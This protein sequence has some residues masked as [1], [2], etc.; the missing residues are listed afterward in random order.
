MK[1]VIFDCDG[2]LVDSQHMI[3]EAMRAAFS[4]SGMAVPARS[5]LVR[6]VGLSVTEA[7][8]AMTGLE[9]GDAVARLAA[10]Y[11]ERAHRS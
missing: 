8:M 7:M 4:A 3:C 2:T 1:L 10:D 5:Q 11:R 6:H 9:E